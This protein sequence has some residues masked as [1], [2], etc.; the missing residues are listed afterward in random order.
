MRMLGRG[1]FFAIAGVGGTI[2]AAGAW[3]LESE[4]FLGS[5]G[6]FPAVNESS[7][8]ESQ[9]I[10]LTADGDEAFGSPLANPVEVDTVRRG[11]LAMRIEA[12]G[13]AEAD[14]RAR[15]AASITGY[16][17][18]VAINEGELVASGQVLLRL[19]PDE[20][21]LAVERGE[22][23]LAEA[24]A[25]YRELTLFDE[26]IPDPEVRRER[27]AEA[28][29]RSGLARTEIALRQVRLGL[30]A[31]TIRAPFAGRVAEI[32][33]TAGDH[34][35]AG[36]DLLTLLDV[37]PIRVQ[38]RVVESELRWLRERGGASVHLVAFPDTIFRGRIAAI[39][40]TVDPEGRT[41]RVTLAVA[42]PDGAILPG[43]FASVTLE[44]RAFHDRLFVPEEAIVERE[45][46]TLVFLFQPLSEGPPEL[47]R[48]RWAYV[49]IGLADDR[50]VEILDSSAS[51]IEAGDLVLTGGHLTLVH[52]ARVRIA[53]TDVRPEVRDSA[54]WGSG[55]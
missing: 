39:S 18:S 30:A 48:A 37:D 36:E 33:V 21:L 42:N 47:G 51:T 6:A 40:P 1:R 52:D 34:V 11:T 35:S 20:A 4:R 55:P 54:S 26:E 25:R 38:V 3:F 22:A 31:T 7:V 44:G 53:G 15:V 13:L 43:M 49:S 14:R 16:V 50:H 2:I 41:G 46:K 12:T 32:R 29:V 27:S 28:R 5:V 45:D 23:E 17:V 24:E 10:V 19:D 9:G 8:A